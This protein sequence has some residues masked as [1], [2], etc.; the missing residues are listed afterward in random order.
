MVTRSYKAT[1][2]DCEVIEKNTK[3]VIHID[4]VVP[5]KRKFRSEKSFREKFFA[6]ESNKEDYLALIS[7][8]VKKY[9]HE[10]YT[11]PDALFKLHAKKE[12]IKWK[13]P[14]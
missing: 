6:D 3:S 7:F 12:V 4:F 2:F 1:I 8:K 10:V 14:K 13:Y 9:T 5:G 11:M